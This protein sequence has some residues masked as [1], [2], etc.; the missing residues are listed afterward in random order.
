MSLPSF[1]N[2][3]HRKANK[4]HRCCE[5]GGLIRVGEKHEYASGVWDGDFR[6][7]RTCSSCEIL[8]NEC[9]DITKETRSYDDGIFSFGELQTELEE[10]LSNFR[11]NDP[12]KII[13]QNKLD[14]IKLRRTTQIG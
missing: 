11:K 9:A 12:E 7:F 14:Q 3:V 5:C 4:E 13:F 1:C 6:A 8:R 10:I 2:I